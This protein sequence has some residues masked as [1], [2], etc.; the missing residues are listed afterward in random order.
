MTSS[1]EPAG[2]DIATDLVEYIVVM[3]PGLDALAPVSRE[4]VR[5]VACEA[6]RILDVVVVS[7]S[8]DGT[9]QVIDVDSSEDLLAVRGLTAGHGILLSQHDI[10]L[11]ALALQPGD[12]AI[13]VVAEDRWAQ[14]L[15]TAA[16]ALGGAVRAGERI[17]RDRVEAALARA[18]QHPMEAEP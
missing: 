5:I 2:P 15:S 18:A 10:E 6:V 14:P 9:P 12:C 13:V 17:A 16:R 1:P 11:I 7:I 8:Q 4:L 3:I